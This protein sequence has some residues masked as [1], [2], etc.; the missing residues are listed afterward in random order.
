[1]NPP[2]PPDD[3]FITPS[4]KF[5]RLIALN[6]TRCQEMVCKCTIDTGNSKTM[7]QLNLP[8]TEQIKCNTKLNLVAKRYA[9]TNHKLNHALKQHICSEPLPCPV[10]CLPKDHKEGNLKGRPIHAATDT[11]A[12]SLSKYLAKSLNPLLRHVPAHLKYKQDFIN[13][14]DKMEGETIHSFCSLDVCKL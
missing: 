4:D 3:V 1:M 5:K 11:P 12:T 7:K 6:S 10:Y 8:R 2:P 14:L 9:R 13:C